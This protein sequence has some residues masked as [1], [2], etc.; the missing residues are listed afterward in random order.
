MSLAYAYL[1][2]YVKSTGI[3]TTEMMMMI[4]KMMM[5]RVIAQRTKFHQ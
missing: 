5:K 1:S 3:I 2:G 4:L